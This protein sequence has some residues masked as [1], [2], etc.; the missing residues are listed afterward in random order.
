MRIADA[1][2]LKLYGL[3]KQY[4]SGLILIQLT[5]IFFEVIAENPSFP[6]EFF[7]TLA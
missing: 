1:A 7:F 3:G 5:A 4:K 2:D 6:Q